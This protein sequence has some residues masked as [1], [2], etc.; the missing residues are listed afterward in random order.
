VTGP[1]FRAGPSRGRAPSARDFALFAAGQAASF[2]GNG[3]FVVALPIEVLR[4]TRSTLALALVVGGDS[5]T[6]VIFMLLGGALVDR[7][8]R[9]R[10]IIAAN[11]VNGVAVAGATALI[12][13]GRIDVAELLATTLILGAAN[14]FLLPAAN[15]IVVDL[16]PPERLTSGNAFLSSAWNLAQ[17][18]G[19]P[20]LGGLVVV[21]AGPAWGFG[22]DGV[23]FLM[24][25]VLI[26]AVRGV[27]R[28][29]GAAAQDGR[30]PAPDAAPSIHAEIKAGLA[31]CRARPWLGWNITAM[32]LM[33]FAGF[34]P[35]SVLL[36]LL[37]KNVLQAGPAA[38]GIVLAAN[39]A[40]GLLG[41][42]A[43]NLIGR[44]RARITAVWAAG[45]FAA[46]G[47]ICLAFAPSPW[48]AAVCVAV[49]W[50]GASY[51]NVVWLSAVQQRVPPALLGRVGALDMMV[52]ILL[53]PAGITASAGISGLI[54][55]R[56]TLLLGGAVALA[57]C[58]TG[59]L[60]AARRIDPPQTLE[61]G[62]EPLR[63]AEA[64][65]ARAS[66]D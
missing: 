6:A 40:G 21:T 56:R 28:P 52:S 9:R 17:Q 14:A 43:V 59:L 37:V 44:R 25:T 10:A 64:G 58:A 36:P 39:G 65:A 53:G 31:Y 3:V 66:A 12:A 50:G 35:L 16:L 38:L 33:N 20:L 34:M 32:G 63:P 54:G 19:G 13:T 26:A 62:P 42:F 5:I 8:S 4:L 1:D 41:S 47:L 57:C 55:V 49:I 61:R 51:S 27:G 24:G 2:L 15:A 48:T 29:G 18:L 23:S 60:P 45:A 11:A 22:I 30:A 46:L 7:F